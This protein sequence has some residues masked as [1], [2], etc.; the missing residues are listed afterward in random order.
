MEGCMQ[1]QPIVLS[2]Y[3]R[4]LSVVFVLFIGLTF[5]LSA[6][7]NGGGGGGGAGAPGVPVDPPIDTDPPA[8][9][10]AGDPATLVLPQLP[11]VSP[12]RAPLEE[13]DAGLLLSRVSIVLNRNAT[14]ADFNAAAQKLGATAIAYSRTNSP[15]LTLIVPR[16]SS[17]A[18][19]KRLAVLLRNQPGILLSV[20]GRQPEGKAL[21]SENGTTVAA[22]SLDHLWPAGFPAAWNLRA[23]AEAD[24]GLRKVTVLVP[25]L[26]VGEPFSGFRDQVPGASENFNAT[27][28]QPR[29]PDA[30]HLHGYEVAAVLAGKFDGAVPTGANPF[31][32]CLKIVPIDLSGFDFFQAAEVIRAAI[33]GE[34]GKVI[35]NGSVGYPIALCGS[36]G[37]NPC[38]EGAIRNAFPVDL[39]EQMAFRVAAGVVWA[40]FAV[41]PTVAN[42]ILLAVAAGNERSDETAGALGQTYAGFRN[43]RLASPFAIATQLS[44]LPAVLA[45]EGL[46]T[47]SDIGYPELMLD[48]ARIDQVLREFGVEAIPPVPDRNLALVGSATQANV[49]SDVDRSLFSNDDADLY[50]VGEGVA[51]LVSTELKGTSI[52]AAQVAGLASYLWLLDDDLRS[53]PVEETL[54][55]IRGTSRANVEPDDKKRVESFIDAYA[56]VLALDALHQTDQIRKTLLDVNNDGL[57]NHLDLQEF[58]ESYQVGNPNA[59]SIPAARDYSRFDLNGDGF[60]GGIL[61]E[62]FDLDADGLEP[63]GAPRFT[64]VTATMGGVAVPLNEAA[65]TDAQIL[66]YYAYGVDSTGAPFY[67]A[68]GDTDD[69]RGT[70]LSRCLGIQM[71]VAFPNRF[72]TSAPLRVTLRQPDGA[73]G[74]APAPNIFVQLSAECATAVPASGRTNGSGE[75]NA[76]VS[77]GSGCADLTL[78]VTAHADEGSPPLAQ[79]TV[80]AFARGL[81]VRLNRIATTKG[82]VTHSGGILVQDQKTSIYPPAQGRD[83][84]P[85]AVALNG[86]GTHSPDPLTSSYTYAADYVESVSASEVESDTVTGGAL[87][88]TASCNAEGNAQITVVTTG[89]VAPYLQFPEGRFRLIIDGTLSGTVRNANFEARFN[90]RKSTSPVQSVLLTSGDQIPSRPFTNNVEVVGPA[91]YELGMSAKGICVNGSPARSAGAEVSVT[92]SIEPLP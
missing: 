74:F 91:S 4:F 82:E 83:Y 79:Q 63:N 73:G 9:Q 20:P 87:R 57:F 6:C 19:V 42:D 84:T 3:K 53:R 22:D 64:T 69:V 66:C 16:Q 37:N 51:G 43:A 62:R 11:N 28:L 72:E 23:R 25:D 1:V 7:G 15:F 86:S 18:A 46:W 60:T 49:V 14:V 29:D 77:F 67:D 33:E 52:S 61:T 50:A 92:F 76:T 32:D 26:Y 12:A 35:V 65:L 27:P 38:L 8:I 80:R 24:C 55:L 34:E 48:S 59:P 78:V 90:L 41:Q 56:A 68:S 89:L 58:A 21:P 75:F 54:R 17:G 88:L 30:V 36:N 31:P 81:G 45:D 85:P 47:F 39:Q 13:V 44:S 40:E 5:F 2:R 71:D 70:L 10:L